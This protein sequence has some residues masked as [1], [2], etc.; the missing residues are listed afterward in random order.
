MQAA[1]RYVGQG[2]RI[3]VAKDETLIVGKPA[4]PRGNELI[5]ES[6]CGSTSREHP[7][8]GKEA[9]LPGEGREKLVCVAFS[10]ARN[11]IVGGKGA[12]CRSGLLG[13]LT[14]DQGTGVAR[15]PCAV[16]AAS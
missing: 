3:A 7:V 4:T 1:L 16:P 13:L 15:K 8:I 5:D 10:C 11:V 2:R 9:T 14:P 12:R 6:S